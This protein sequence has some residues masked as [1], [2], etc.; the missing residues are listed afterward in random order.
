MFSLEGETDGWIGL[1]SR[2]W[3]LNSNLSQ[4][5][6]VCWKKEIKPGL[7]GRNHWQVVSFLLKSVLAAKKNIFYENQS[8]AVK[9]G[10]TYER[11]LFDNRPSRWRC[12]R[13]SMLRLRKRKSNRLAGGERELIIKCIIAIIDS[14][15]WKVWGLIHTQRPWKFQWISHHKTSEPG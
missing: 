13:V 9:S 6:V 8:D 12:G 5:P 15:M 4:T 10:F 2:S 7:I 14:W 3:L 1:I 11:S